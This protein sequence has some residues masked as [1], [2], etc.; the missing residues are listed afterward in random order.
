MSYQAVRIEQMIYMYGQRGTCRMLRTI[1]VPLDRRVQ[2][3]ADC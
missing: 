2:F 3:V 1:A